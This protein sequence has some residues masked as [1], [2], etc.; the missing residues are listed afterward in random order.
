MLAVIGFESRCDAAGR[1]KDRR[2]GM[3]AMGYCGFFTDVSRLME[4]A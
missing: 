4:L 2:R 1:L 3:S